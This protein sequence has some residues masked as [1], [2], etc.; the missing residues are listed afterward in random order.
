[1]TI[2]AF[3]TALTAKTST[4]FLPPPSQTDTYAFDA[5]F[6]ASWPSLDIQLLLAI[7]LG[8][9]SSSKSYYLLSGVTAL[10]QLCHVKA[11]ATSPEMQLLDARHN[12]A[13]NMNNSVLEAIASANITD[14]K[15][16][17]RNH[18]SSIA[19]GQHEMV[20]LSRTIGATLLTVVAV[21]FFDIHPIVLVPPVFAQAAN[22]YSPANNPPPKSLLQDFNITTNVSKGLAGKVESTISPAQSTNSSELPTAPREQGKKGR[23]SGGSSSGGG[24]AATCSEGK[25]LTMPTNTPFQI[26]LAVI[27][28]MALDISPFWVAATALPGRVHAS[29]ESNSIRDPSQLLESRDAGNA[30]NMSADAVNKGCDSKFWCGP[31]AG[32]GPSMQAM[33]SMPLVLGVAFAAT[34]LLSPQG[35]GYY[36]VFLLLHPGAMATPDLT[37]SKERRTF[38]P[39]ALAIT[40]FPTLL[41]TSLALAPF[42][43]DECNLFNWSSTE[44]PFHRSSSATFRIHYRDIATP[45]TYV[46]AGWALDSANAPNIPS[47][48]ESVVH[49]C[50]PVTATPT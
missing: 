47:A 38:A 45:V 49:C 22:A 46:E 6:T 41:P 5:W 50:T 20:H 11:A 13:E 48:T 33:L 4:A 9:R 10:S 7:M 25:P 28:V 18:T 43:R 32:Q 19:P 16:T 3:T 31:H 29:P 24:C 36:L 1:M 27:T 40:A 14:K 44:Q 35:L 26:G 21:T 37:I 17:P 30:S 34:V 15:G 39:E 23:D 42:G 2:T 8:S 12:V